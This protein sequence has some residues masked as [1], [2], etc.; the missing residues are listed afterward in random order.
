MSVISIT[1]KNQCEQVLSDSAGYVVLLFVA[2]WHAPCKQMSSVLAALAKEH[3]SITFA[4]VDAEVEGIADIPACS[5][6]ASVPT[7][8]ALFQ[9]K[10]LDTLTGVSVPKLVALVG[11]LSKQPLPTSSNPTILKEELDTRLGQL[12]R[13]API[14]LFMKGSPEAPR[15]GFSRTIAG[16]LNEAAGTGKYGFFDILTDED[17]RQGLKTFSNWPSYPQLY[18]DGELIGGLDIVKELHDEG[19]LAKTISKAL[20][21]KTEELNARLHKLINQS[22]VMLFMKGGPSKPQ[23]GFSR[24]M[25]ELLTKAGFLD[26]GFFDILTDL[27]VREGLK[28][29]S[30]WPTY[31]QLYIGGELVGGLDVVTELIESGELKCAPAS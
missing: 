20:T 8:L 11:K 25:V 1:S 30:N 12:I 13:A 14:M 4:Q 17:V 29:Y 23:C 5:G 24:K 22:H 2:A 27:E 16:I 3:S 21:K 19:E 9:S 7:T 28:K 26:F 6:V 31:P 10:V 15:C 18:I